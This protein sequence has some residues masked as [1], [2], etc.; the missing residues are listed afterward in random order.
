MTFIL[1]SGN[2]FL[3]FGGVFLVYIVARN[4]IR[5]YRNYVRRQLDQSD[6]VIVSGRDVNINVNIENTHRGRDIHETIEDFIID[7]ENCTQEGVY[8]SD[9]VIE[10][11]ICL[12]NIE[13]HDNIR[14]LSCFHM[15]HTDCIDEWLVRNP[16]CPI[17]FQR[18]TECIG[19]VTV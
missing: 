1:T 17:C 16:T 2:I 10:C 15:Y 6:I 18:I 4:I 5:C 3:I 8:N 7:I 13:K 14:T 19:V 9:F 11:I 12:E